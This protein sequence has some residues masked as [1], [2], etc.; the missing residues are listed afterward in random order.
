MDTQQVQLL[1][2]ELDRGLFLAS[3][4]FQRRLRALILDYLRMPVRPASQAGKAY[5]AEP[6]KLL[7][8]VEGFFAAPDGPGALP[9]PA[10]A[11]RHTLPGLVLP[12]IDLRVGG[13]TY[14]HGYKA[15]LEDSQADLVVVLG[16]AHQGP[17]EGLFSVSTKDFATPLG[18]VRVARGMCERLQ[19]VSDV[20]APVAEYA[21]RGEH[22]VEFQAVIL[23]ALLHERLGRDFELVP[24]L[25]GPVEPFL[26][27][28]RSPL[29]DGHFKRF[30]ETLRTELDGARRRW[31]VLAS[32]DFSHV[33]P[34]FGDF[35]PVTERLLPP[36]RRGDERL[37]SRIES[38]D[39]EGFCAE[40]V[41]T[42]NSRH[43][44]AAVPVLTLLA[45]GKGLFKRARRLHYDQML[46]V[47]TKSVVSF[48]SLAFEAEDN[49]QSE[50]QAQ[51]DGT[52]H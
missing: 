33:G 23:Q 39:A 52:L 27:E 30:V 45:L 36:V 1:A 8:M 24:I 42:H 25:C 11:Q 6:D 17:G 26:A 50:T 16:V 10:P 40:I 32:V 19:K 44:D 2:D 7:R 20:E 51:P 31:S 34:K 35:T 15:L 28:E 29:E 9:P 46:E 37:L 38:L 43:V 21:H 3:P 12:H 18:T 48:A 47:P 41:R 4:R 5:P 22:S 13:A 14:A 49:F